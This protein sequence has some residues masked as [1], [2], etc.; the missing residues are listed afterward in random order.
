[1]GKIES[2]LERIFREWKESRFRVCTWPWARSGGT[3]EAKV[4]R[5]GWLPLTSCD[6]VFSFAKWKYLTRSLHYW[7]KSSYYCVLPSA[8]LIS[9]TGMSINGWL[10]EGRDTCP[11]SHSQQQAVEPGFKPRYGSLQLSKGCACNDHAD[12]TCVLETERE[13]D[14]V[15]DTTQGSVLEG[16]QALRNSQTSLY[17]G[18]EAGSFENTGVGSQL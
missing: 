15:K 1:M 10:R 8:R 2:R 11:R 3:M 16:G 6:F 7:T 17:S 9:E 5:L 14:S 18:L 4:P 12:F 13:R